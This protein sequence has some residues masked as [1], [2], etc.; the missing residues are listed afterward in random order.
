MKAVPMVSNMPTIPNMRFMAAS[1]GARVS[2]SWSNEFL[3]A[4]VP[5]PRWSCCGLDRLVRGLDTTKRKWGRFR[6]S[7][8]VAER[9]SL[10]AFPFIV[11]VLPL[12]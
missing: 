8:L 4:H 3:A 6:R 7:R 9:N 1:P 10:N 11:A 12:W 2:I 5:Q